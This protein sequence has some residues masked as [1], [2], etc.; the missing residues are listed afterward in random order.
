[1][2]PKQTRTP[3]RLKNAARR[4]AT[5]AERGD[6]RGAR[7]ATRTVAIMSAAF[8]RAATAENGEA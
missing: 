8:N 6:D 2:N 1:M 5:L 4:A 3:K 7:R